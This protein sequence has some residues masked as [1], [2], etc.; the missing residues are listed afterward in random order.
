LIENGFLAFEKN[1]V[2]L[3]HAVYIENTF[4]SNEYDVGDTERGKQKTGR[5]ASPGG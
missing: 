4:G 5:P 3:T 1:I 2:V